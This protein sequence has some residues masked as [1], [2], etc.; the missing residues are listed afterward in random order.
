[1]G[2]GV[3]ARVKQKGSDPVQEGRLEANM[4]NN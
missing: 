1:M 2:N 3:T 4:V